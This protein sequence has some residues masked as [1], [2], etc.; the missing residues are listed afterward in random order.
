MDKYFSNENYDRK[1]P[2]ASPDDA[3][4][5][6]DLR[7][8]G[9]DKGDLGFGFGAT[10]ARGRYDNA[11]YDSDE[12]ELDSTPKGSSQGSSKDLSSGDSSCRNR[13][14]EVRLRYDADEDDNDDEE[15]AT[16]LS[17]ED[18]DGWMQKINAK[19]Q[20]KFPVSPASTQSS[21]PGGSTPQI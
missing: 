14:K 17:L 20:D 4:D 11:G 13:N 10:V 9:G 2:D 19:M 15:T 7:L 8:G 21:G 18:L 12:E 5:D 1:K 3:E 16:G 6:D